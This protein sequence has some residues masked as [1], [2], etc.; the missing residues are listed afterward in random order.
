MTISLK[1]AFESAIPDGGDSGLVQP[2]N[3]NDEHVLRMATARIIGRTSADEGVAEELEAATVRTFLDLIIGTTVQAY[4]A[5]LDA[6]A[7]LDPTDFSTT[8]E[9]V[10]AIATALTGYQPLDSDLSALAANSSNGLWAR[11]SEGS[12]AARTIEGTA[13]Q[14]SVSNGD[15]VAGNPTLSLPADVLIPTVVTIPNLGLHLLDTNGTHDLII[16]PGSNL[17]ADRT[18]TITTGDTDLILNL[19]DP[20]ADRLMFWDDSAGEWV[21]LTLAAGLVISGT[22]IRA[23]ESF[24]IACSDETTNLTTGTAKVKWRMPYAFTVTAVRASLTVAQT[25]GSIFTVDINES[26]TSI[27]STKLTIDNNELTSTTAATPA[28]ISDADLADDAEMSID[29]DQ[30][31]TAL[32]KGLKVTIIGYRP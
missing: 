10:T 20:G 27:L 31:G 1:H 8:A 5:N 12:G 15:G 14:I 24:V 7:L 25:T 19:T 17:T 26:G 13:N 11:V 28:V 9:V 3:W 16:A 4:A 32:A 30:I 23:T 6:W 21:A 22:E 2:S 29:I 18:L